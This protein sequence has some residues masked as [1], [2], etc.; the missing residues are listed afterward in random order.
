MSAITIEQ[1]QAAMAILNSGEANVQQMSAASQVIATF[2]TQTTQALA[3]AKRAMAT[4]VH[5]KTTEKGSLGL[6]NLPGYE[7]VDGQE[8]RKY[9]K[10]GEEA[11]RKFP[12]TLTPRQ[13]VKVRE[14]VLSGGLD[15]MLS[16]NPNTAQAIKNN[17]IK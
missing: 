14:I 15:D 7:M 8:K 16:A 6:Y 1:F 17:P 11:T 5:F 9:L 3:T 12:I 4:T 13:W 2:T 10:D